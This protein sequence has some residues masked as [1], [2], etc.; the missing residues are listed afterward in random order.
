MPHPET[1]AFFDE[2]KTPCR[3]TKAD[4]FAAA[5]QFGPAL[6]LLS[7]QIALF[8]RLLQESEIVESDPTLRAQY[9]E[10]FQNLGALQRQARDVEDAARKVTNT[11][12]GFSD[13]LARM[14][15]AAKSAGYTV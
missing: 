2:I 12:R 15:E 7:E 5:K 10:A 3:T 8:R 13:V 6:G 4:V 11:F 14:R 1:Q 9:E